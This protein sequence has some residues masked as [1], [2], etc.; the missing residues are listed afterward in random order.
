MNKKRLDNFARWSPILTSFVAVTMAI[1]G[2]HVTAIIASVIT[3]TLLI[4]QAG[5]GVFP[6]KSTSYSLAVCWLIF[7]VLQIAVLMLERQRLS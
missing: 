7:A 3:V 1:V 5:R 4:F 2:W 6:E